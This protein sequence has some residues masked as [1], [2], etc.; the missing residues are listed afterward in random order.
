VRLVNPPHAASVLQY[1]PFQR[2]AGARVPRTLIS[3]DPPAVRAFH[4]EVGDVIF[5]PLMGG[6]LTQVLEGDVLEQ[7]DLVRA[8]PGIDIKRTPRGEWVFL[9]PHLPGRRAQAGPP[10]QPR[11][12]R[13]RAGATLR[14]P[15]PESREIRGP[16]DPPSLASFMILPVVLIGYSLSASRLKK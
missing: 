4:A 14:R 2:M 3:N 8:A 10:H 16:P 12:R 11:R 9:E 13:A 7:L 1:K 5:K 6:A 15:R